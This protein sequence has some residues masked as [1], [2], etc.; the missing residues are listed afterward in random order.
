LSINSWHVF[1]TDTKNKREIILNIFWSRALSFQETK[2]PFLSSDQDHS[3]S[4]IKNCFLNTARALNWLQL[5]HHW[6]DHQ[7]KPSIPFLHYFCNLFCTEVLVLLCET[8]IFHCIGLFSIAITW[9]G[10]DVCIGGFVKF[11]TCWRVQQGVFWFIRWS[12][13]SSWSVV[14]FNGLFRAGC[15]FILAG[16]KCL[17]CCKLIWLIFYSG[18]PYCGVR[19]WT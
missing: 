17:N 3:N 12:L 6:S 15:S 5:F 14:G 16:C 19:D 18:N 4:F 2:V 13:Y 9:C 8:H 1:E 10:N 11:V 7:T